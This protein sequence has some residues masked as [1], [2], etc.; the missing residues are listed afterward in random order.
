MSIFKSL[1]CRPDFASMQKRLERNAEIRKS[2]GLCIRTGIEGTFR[3]PRLAGF[4]K[5]CLVA[6]GC[7]EFFSKAL[8]EA[9]EYFLLADAAELEHGRLFMSSR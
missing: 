6:D 5:E 4:V 3:P 1:P 9:F 7:T 8:V 2:G